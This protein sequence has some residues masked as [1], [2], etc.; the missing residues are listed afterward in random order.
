MKPNR[1][2]L[3]AL[4]TA[5]TVATLLAFGIAFARIESP[6][7]ISQFEATI[8]FLPLGISSDKADSLIGS[9]PDS[10]ALQDGVLASPVTM[11]AASNEQ[12]RK[13]GE[14]QTYSLRV[15]ERGGVKG[16]V[17]VDRNGLVAGRWTVR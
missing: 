9:P 16:V 17:A 10:V 7:P 5:T 3:V 6:R 13:Y 2:R 1:V 15:W 8:A 4:A 11:F 12:G 14:P